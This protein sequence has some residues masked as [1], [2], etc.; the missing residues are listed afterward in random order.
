MDL[1]CIYS[2]VSQV[3]SSTSKPSLAD[4]LNVQIPEPSAP[5]VKFLKVKLEPEPL[6]L[7]STEES[8]C[9]NLSV[10]ELSLSPVGAGSSVCVDT[11]N[12][13]AL[14]GQKKSLILGFMRGRRGYTSSRDPSRKYSPRREEFYSKLI[15]CASPALKGSSSRSL[16]DI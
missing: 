7:D 1:S 5:K 10:E 9:S 15:S 3:S 14:K 11:Q 16:L 12:R 8:S 13:R 6:D 2:Q 4:D